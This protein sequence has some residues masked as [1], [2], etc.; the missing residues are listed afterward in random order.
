MSLFDRT[1]K[2]MRNAFFIVMAST[3]GSIEVYC[4]ADFE[5]LP[6]GFFRVKTADGKESLGYRAFANQTVYDPKRKRLK[7]I[8]APSSLGI[9]WQVCERFTLAGQVI[10]LDRPRAALPLV[11]LNYLR[12]SKGV[13]HVGDRT[14]VDTDAIWGGGET[15][16]EER[17]NTLLSV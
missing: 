12:P 8:Q 16:W 17:P 2:T 5:R 9:M 7:T 10:Q 6:F 15:E 1:T 11:R 3:K 14:I 4:A 13:M